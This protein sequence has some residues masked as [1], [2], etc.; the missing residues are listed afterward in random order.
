MSDGKPTN[1]IE[2]R[3]DR[4]LAVT[5]RAAGGAAVGAIAGL[6]VPSTVLFGAPLI[7]AAVAGLA[8]G[9]SGVFTTLPDDAKPDQASR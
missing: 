7:A 9:L 8:G 5:S 1:F 6:A 3:A 4:I 2:D